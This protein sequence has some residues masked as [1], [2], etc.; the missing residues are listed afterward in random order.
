VIY[1]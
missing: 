1:A